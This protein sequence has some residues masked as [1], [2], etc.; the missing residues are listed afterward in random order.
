MHTDPDYS[1]AYLTFSTDSE[2]TGNGF[3]FTLGRGTD[4]CVEA[5]R[6]LGE[7]LVGRQLADITNNFADVWRELTSDS[8]FR[9]LGPEKGVVH[10]YT[11]A[12]VNRSGIC[13]PSPKAYHFGNC[14]PICQRNR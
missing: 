3:T 5:A 6:T 9:W 12:V 7:L 10:L 4:L 13:G 11:A 8:Q 14:W 1:A 2:T